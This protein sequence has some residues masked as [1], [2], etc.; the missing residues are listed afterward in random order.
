MPGIYGYISFQ[1]DENI[2]Q[3][4]DSLIKNNFFVE[5]KTI[6]NNYFCN[7]QTHKLVHRSSFAEQGK[8]LCMLS[9]EIF[10]QHRPDFSSKDNDTE[11]FLHSYLNLGKE[12][13]FT[14]INGQFGACI[15]NKETEEVI[16][17]TD[18]FGTK[19]I[20][21]TQTDDSFIFSPEVKALVNHKPSFEDIDFLNNL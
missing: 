9:G 12:L 13:V 8:F 15:F 19:P 4:V 7:I 21:Y 3:S 5:S 11:Y 17:V 20:Y 16:L 14:S 10:D 2:E 1:P 18:R 6:N